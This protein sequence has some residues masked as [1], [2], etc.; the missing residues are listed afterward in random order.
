MATHWT[1][2]APPTPARG[3]LGYIPEPGYDCAWRRVD[4]RSRR[5]P[6]KVAKNRFH[7]DIRVAGEGAADPA[8]SASARRSSP[9]VE[10]ISAV[11]GRPNAL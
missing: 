8:A 10:Y 7:I 3:V 1:G 9:A 11:S 4:R 2:A 6:A 5:G